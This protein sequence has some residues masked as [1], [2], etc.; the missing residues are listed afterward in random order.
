MKTPFYK[1]LLSFLYPVCI[2]QRSS[3]LHPVLDLYLYRNQWQLG[4]KDAWYSDGKRYRPLRTAF[5][6]IRHEL[7]G[8]HHVLVLG[9]GLA[10]AVH[11]L[12]DMGFHPAYTLVD[13]DNDILLLAVELMPAYDLTRVELVCMDAQLFM[14]HNQKK[15]PLIVCDVFMGRNVP[16]FVSSATFLE[17]CKAGLQPGGRLI[18]NYL[19]KGKPLYQEMC[20]LMDRVFPGYVLIEFGINKIFLTPLQG[21]FTHVS[22]GE[23]G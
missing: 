9:T 18:L 17:Q 8:T 15:Y 4:T 19:E 3:P 7:S 13:I 12:E 1:R 21:S 14:Q 11:I 10:S 22:E 5:R 6:K 20:Q 16:G 2:E 23:I